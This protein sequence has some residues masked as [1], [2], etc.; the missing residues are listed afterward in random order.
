MVHIT[1]RF[2]SP[3]CQPAPSAPP[4]SPSA[5][6]PCPS[7]STR[8]PSPR[9]AC[10]STCCTRS[11]A[12]GSSSST[13]APRTTTKSS[14]ATTPSK[15]TSSRRISTSSCRTEE[16]K[17][18]EEKATG[19]ID[20]IEFVPLAKVDREYLEKVYYL[21][22]DK[23]GDRAYRL[24][25]AAL[26]ETGTRRARPVRRARTAAPRPAS[27]AQ[28][29][30]RDG[31]AA[32]RRRSAP[33]DRGHRSRGR[34]EADASSRS[35]S[36]SSSRRRNENFEPTK[37]KDTVRERVLETIQRKVEGQDITPTMRRTTR[38]QD[39]RPHGGAQG[40]PRA[41]K[42]A[43]GQGRAEAGPKAS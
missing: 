27:A 5:S 7:T 25:A 4:P 37:Y 10:R 38:R 33:D 29:R 41:T 32:L 24:L 16:L 17:A 6:S 15:A 3:P 2:H 26:K 42:P 21:G 9:R 35:P 36:S 18:L 34:R 43:S 19:M 8:P 13:S 11:A 22:P 12:A 39:H 40:E 20:V 1:L 31:A 30:A 28:W 14:T 23:G